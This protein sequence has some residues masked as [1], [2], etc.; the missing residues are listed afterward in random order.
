MLNSNN[1]TRRRAVDA[2]F[3][4]APAAS[5]PGYTV[6][7]PHAATT[8]N[9]PPPESVAPE[10]SEPA[11][12]AI[13]S[14]QRA[15]EIPLPELAPPAQPATLPEDPRFLTLS[16]QIERL[17]EDVKTQLRDSATAT[18]YCF[19]LLLQARQA[20]ESRDYAS[21]EFFI[22]AADAK[23][24]RSERSMAALSSPSVI[25]VWLWEGLA[26]FGGGAIIALTY[27]VNLTLF[28]LPVATELSVLIRAMGWGI[29]GGVLG[30][31]YNLP[32]FFQ[33]REYD[34]AFTM[35]YFA[36]PFKGLLVGAVLFLTSQA[37][38]LAGN[39]TL[40][41]DIRLGPVFLYV[42]AALAGFKQEY[43][44]EFFDNLLKTIFRVPQLPSGLKPPKPPQ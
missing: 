11:P 6:E 30:A 34:P 39:L 5:A 17:Y 38:I 4:D 15:A 35:D 41:G 1:G 26:F 43:V 27:V 36:R 21:A 23:L 29:I 19:E 44:T 2:L 37:G 20:Y 25:L 3:G 7:M 31:V 24:K 28:G 10:A 8:V 32:W 16:F 12:P 14:E 40:P 22:Q 18:N 13:F 42:I 33:F 9:P